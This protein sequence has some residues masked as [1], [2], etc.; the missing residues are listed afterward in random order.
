MCENNFMT[1]KE[2]MESTIPKYVP[3]DVWGSEYT[4]KDLKLPAA[5]FVETSMTVKDA[6]ELFK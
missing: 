6:I 5:K 2:C 3:H 4:L 1:E